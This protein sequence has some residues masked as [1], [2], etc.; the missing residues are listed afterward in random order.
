M[1]PNP[2]P[3]PVL[4]LCDIGIHN[5]R[6]SCT[7]SSL[8]LL[9]EI[10]QFPDPE[11]RISQTLGFE[12]FFLCVL[13]P[14]LSSIV[15]RRRGAGSDAGIPAPRKSKESP[16]VARIQGGIPQAR[17][18]TGSIPQMRRYYYF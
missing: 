17:K 12:D 13:Q 8:G 5:L 15:V 11:I 10:H 1:L 14:F 4:K 18:S 3:D 9:W 16:Q 2:I 6:T 7:I